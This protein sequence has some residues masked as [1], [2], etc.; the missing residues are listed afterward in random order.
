V[1]AMW[2]FF[3]VRF[4]SFGAAIVSESSSDFFQLYMK[5]ISINSDHWGRMKMGARLAENLA[6]L[7]QVVRWLQP[8]INARKNTAD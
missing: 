1:E 8:I 6:L 7:A 5:R 2:I 4:H 3:H